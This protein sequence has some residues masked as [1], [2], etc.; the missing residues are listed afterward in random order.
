MKFSKLSQTNLSVSKICLGTMTFGEQNTESDAHAQ[1]DYAFERGV[2]FIDTAEMYPVPPEQKTQGLTESFIGTWLKK[3]GNRKDVI[4]ATKVS[5]PAA[6]MPYIRNGS[7]LDKENIVQA[8]ESSLKRLN[9]DYIDLYQVHWPSRNTNFFGQYGYKHTDENFIPIQETLE[10]LNNA[11]KSGK[12]RH[13]GVSNETPWGVMQFLVSAKKNKWPRIVS[14]QNPYNFLNRT[15]EIGL[16]E[17]SHREDAG[18]LAYS[19]LAFGIL[20]GKYLDNQKPKGARLTLWSSFNRYNGGQA[21]TATKDY[22]NLAKKFN[23]T[24]AQLALSFVTNQPFV[25]S[26]IIGATNLQQLKE[27]IDSIDIAL[28]DDMQEEIEKIHQRYPNPCP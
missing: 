9:T 7:N 3:T 24:P 8:I 27:N 21:V 5:G 1:L 20:T 16:A 10:V 23:I 28:T 12:I 11:V 6:F 26:N 13:I 18:L 22:V 4:I 15:Y 14:I 2:N 19:P 25:T 17:F